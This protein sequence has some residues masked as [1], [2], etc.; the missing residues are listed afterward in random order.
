MSNTLSNEVLA[1]LFAQESNDPFL[2]LLT[3][4]HPDFISDIFLVNNTVD[5]TSRGQVYSALP[6]KIRVPTDDGETARSFQID[7]DNAALTMMTAIRSVTTA[8][9]VKLEM[10]LASMPDVVQISQEDLTIA[11]ITYTAT[12]LTARI[13]LDGFLNVAMTSEQYV[14]KN[15]PG[16]F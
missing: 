13:V 3:L 7:M 11:T 6:M 14:P 15:F 5:I 16:I 1:Q 8:I 12:S 9:S 2:T 4:S 10:I